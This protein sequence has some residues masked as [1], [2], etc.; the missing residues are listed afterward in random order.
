MNIVFFC[1]ITN[2]ILKTFYLQRHTTKKV[3]TF[4]QFEKQRPIKNDLND[5]WILKV[6]IFCLWMIN[7]S[8]NCLNQMT[9]TNIACRFE[10]QRF[11]FSCQ[12]SRT[13]S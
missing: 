10:H 9:L 8:T 7:K 4:S 5:Y 3:V 1:P 13:Y 2:Q 11:C 6:T 12:T